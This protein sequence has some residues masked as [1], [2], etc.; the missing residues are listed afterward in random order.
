MFADEP[1]GALDTSTARD[2]LGLLRHSAQTTGQ[3][4]VMVTHDPV[5]A[6][7]ANRVLFLADGHLVGELLAPTADAVAERMTRLGAFVDD[8]SLQRSAIS[9]E[10]SR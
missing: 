6:A 7:Y 9:G 3:T 4:I 8:T 1:T 10:G 2:V 5:A